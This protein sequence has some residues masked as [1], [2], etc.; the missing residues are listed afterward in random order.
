MTEIVTGHSRSYPLMSV[1][2]DASE[3]VMNGRDQLFMSG[4]DR[5]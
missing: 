5:S 4:H 3:P 2:H 1:G